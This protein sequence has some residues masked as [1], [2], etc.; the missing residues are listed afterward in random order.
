MALEMIYQKSFDS[1]SIRVT[2]CPKN[3]EKSRDAVE[4][5]VTPVHFRG[6]ASKR[7]I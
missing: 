7:F 5:A 6:F 1:D 3:A 4:G 2:V